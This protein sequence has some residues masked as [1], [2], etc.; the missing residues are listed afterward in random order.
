MVHGGFESHAYGFSGKQH[1][2]APGTVLVVMDKRSY[3]VF[4][5][6]FSLQVL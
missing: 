5:K 4:L 1:L 6:V 3:R 2:S